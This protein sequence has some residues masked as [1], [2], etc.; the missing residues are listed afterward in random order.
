[1]DG[2]RT[3]AHTSGSGE[4]Q[5]SLTEIPMLTGFDVDPARGPH[6]PAPRRSRRH[7]GSIGFSTPT[8]KPCFTCRALP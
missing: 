4:G 7:P 3:F 8:M 6:R 5:V 1:M 2:Q